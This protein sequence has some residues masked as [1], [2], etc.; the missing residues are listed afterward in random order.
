[1]AS[2][3]QLTGN[4]GI[5]D[6]TDEARQQMT[7][8]PEKPNP[9]AAIARSIAN[10][11]G[12]AITDIASIPKR[13]FESSE[14]M[15]KGGEYDPGP[16]LEATPAGMAMR[17]ERMGLEAAKTFR[18]VA[19]AAPKTTAAA[20]GGA[21]AGLAAETTQ[22]AAEDQPNPKLGEISKIEA[23]MGKLQE[24]ITKLGTT[25]MQSTKARELTTS[26][27]Q[28]QI[29]A[30]QMRL[31]ELHGQIVEEEKEAKDVAAAKAKAE[32][33]FWQR[34]A[35]WTAAITPTMMGVAGVTGNVA[36]GYLGRKNKAVRDA[37][38]AALDEAKAHLKKTGRV[39]TARA[40]QLV[41]ELEGHQEKGMPFGPITGM[42]GS[43]LSGTVEG[44]AVP[45]G[46]AE[47]D[48]HFLPQGSPAQVQAEKDLTDPK[49]WQSEVGGSAVEGAVPAGIGGKLRM[50][51][52]G[53][54]RAPKAETK[55]ALAG[56]KEQLATP[57]T[58]PRKAAPKKEE[59]PR[60]PAPQPAPPPPLTAEAV[61]QRRKLYGVGSKQQ[62]QFN[63]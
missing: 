62:G 10:I 9:D 53:P 21:G 47:I 37:W 12:G 6:M 46:I 51:R 19:R 59:P 56:L 17:P 39:N 20:A 35:P 14:T 28:A 30:K 7:H 45:I 57:P 44:A 23:E 54:W 33:A 2:L 29:N 16:V 3:D 60:T 48:K 41:A 38:N 50:Q 18:D 32:S 49:W 5:T 25:K 15:R 63:P 1:M 4:G 52:M 42:V 11:F 26:S 43:A 22:S 55:G 34:Y 40:K 58:P 27:L 8:F 36:G 13:A 61:R 24:E 31:Q